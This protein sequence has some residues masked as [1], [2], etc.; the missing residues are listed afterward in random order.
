MDD[1][2][3]VSKALLEHETLTGDE[4]K[5]ILRGETINRDDIGRPLPTPRANVAKRPSIPT[6][7][8]GFGPE[9]QEG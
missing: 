8:G 9:P 5:A 1:L 2:H 6:T 7:I 4:I 3:T